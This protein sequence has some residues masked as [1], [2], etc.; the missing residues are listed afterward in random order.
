MQAYQR[1]RRKIDQ[2]KKSPST[3]NRK[4]KKSDEK[5]FTEEKE[6]GAKA[7]SVSPGKQK[8]KR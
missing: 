7:D 5:M 2:I 8:L 4:D 3:K 1:H 6:A